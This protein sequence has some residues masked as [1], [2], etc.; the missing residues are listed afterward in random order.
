M[1]R[2]GVTIMKALRMITTLATMSAAAAALASEAETSATAGGRLGGLGTAAAS[3][4]Y[5][6]DVGFARTT[7]TSG[8]ISAARGVAV[9]ADA[10]GLSLSVSQAVAPLLGPALA[11]SFNLSI[12]RDGQVSSSVG[13]G[14]AQG[15]TYQSASAGGS[16]G[17]GRAGASAH[18][19]GRT[20]SHGRV[21]VVTRADDGGARRA[22]V[23]REAVS[24]PV[25]RQVRPAVRVYRP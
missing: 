3:A 20:D 7:S 25:I 8:R 17:T 10:D 19:S 4:R 16:V 18:A 23:R 22:P 24:R 15:R 9:G 14:M 21:T 1:L 11:T 5:E 2:I 13:L 6:G 12:G